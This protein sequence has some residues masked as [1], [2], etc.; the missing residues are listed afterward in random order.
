LSD[1]NGEDRSFLAE[2]DCLMYVN[3]KVTTEG[4]QRGKTKPIWARGPA[5]R[6]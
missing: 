2:F 1:F 3:V 5:K 6:P 4:F